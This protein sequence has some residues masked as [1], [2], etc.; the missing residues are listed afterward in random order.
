MVDQVIEIYATMEIYQSESCSVWTPPH[1]CDWSQPV[2]CR[3]SET[4][5][6]DFTSFTTHRHSHIRETDKQHMA[7]HGRQTLKLVVSTLP[8]TTEPCWAA[9]NPERPEEEA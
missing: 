6:R 4:P 1:T 9:A 2:A 3:A 7:H 5:S 8:V